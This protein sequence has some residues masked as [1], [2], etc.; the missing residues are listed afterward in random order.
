MQE[1]QAEGKKDGAR[2]TRTNI[3]CSARGCG[4]PR[5]DLYA[6]KNSSH[7]GCARETPRKLPC[8]APRHA[9]SLTR[10][11]GFRLRKNRWKPKW[12]ASKEPWFAP[13]RWK[14]KGFTVSHGNRPAKKGF[15]VSHENRR[16]KVLRRHVLRIQE[17]SEVYRSIQ[18]S[19]DGGY[20]PM[21]TAQFDDLFKGTHLLREAMRTCPLHREGK[22]LWYDKIQTSALYRPSFIGLYI[23]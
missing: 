5:K 1:G 8:D 2:T 16:K 12:I 11:T 20:V 14:K 13:R 9:T 18:E 15:T 3:G 7:M 17:G 6:E 19:M 23:V 22:V 21:Y 10:F 4:S